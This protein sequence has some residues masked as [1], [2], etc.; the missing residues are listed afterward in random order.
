MKIMVPILLM[1]CVMTKDPQVAF[2]QAL[3]EDALIRQ[4]R[5]S[6]PFPVFLKLTRHIQGALIFSSR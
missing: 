6:P 2:A 5:I 3:H 1:A 4:M